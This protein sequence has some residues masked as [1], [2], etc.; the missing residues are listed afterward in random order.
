MLFV[1]LLYISFIMFRYVPWISHL[2][3]TFS[4]KGYSILSKAFSPSNEVILLFY[5]EFVYM[6]DYTD[7]FSYIELSLHPWNEAYLIVVNDVFDVFWD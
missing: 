2:S 1:G 4:I 7:T 6:T 5:F 3:K